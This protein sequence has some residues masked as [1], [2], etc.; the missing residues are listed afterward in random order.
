MAEGL[1]TPVTPATLATLVTSS[2]PPANSDEDG[3]R[4]Q[5]GWKR[6][7]M[8]KTRQLEAKHAV[9]DCALADAL[10]REG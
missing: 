5:N 9:P 8:T 1:A 4:E 6:M 10:T 3:K 2:S 7:Q